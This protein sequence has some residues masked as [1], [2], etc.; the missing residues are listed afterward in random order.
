MAVQ[1]D[2]SIKESGRVGVFHLFKTILQIL[3]LIGISKIYQEVLDINIDRYNIK[4]LT[5]L[6]VYENGNPDPCPEC[7]KLETW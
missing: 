4:L 6:F 1:F 3:T 7:M 2:S 5:S